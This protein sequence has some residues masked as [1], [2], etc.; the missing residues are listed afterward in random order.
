MRKRRVEAKTTLTVNGKTHTW[1]T[2]TVENGVDMPGNSVG[3]VCSSGPVHISS[4]TTINDEGVLRR[5]RR[6]LR[7]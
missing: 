2:D 5:I 6:M 1:V 3:S 7:R 4:K